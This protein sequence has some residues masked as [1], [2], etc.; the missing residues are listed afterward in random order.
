[1]AA[2]GRLEQGRVAAGKEAL[3]REVLPSAEFSSSAPVLA[4]TPNSC[5]ANRRREPSGPP[6]GVPFLR[7]KF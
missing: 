2:R 7:I 4:S 5:F 1:M 3:S 6:F